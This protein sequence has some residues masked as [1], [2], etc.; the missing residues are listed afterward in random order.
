MTNTILKAVAA[1]A[2]LGMSAAAL[3]APASAHDGW[4]GA[5]LV[6]LGVGAVIGSALA[7]RTVY[8]APPPPPPAYPVAYGPPPWSPAWYSYCSSAHPSF[9]PQTGYFYTYSGEPVFCR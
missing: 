3:P 7:P 8:V 6:G 5:G 1:T 2:L 9:N 4:V